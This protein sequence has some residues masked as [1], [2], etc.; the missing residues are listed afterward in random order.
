MAIACE[1][2]AK[3]VKGKQALAIES[4]AKALRQLPIIIAQNAGFDAN[5]LIHDLQIELS[6]R[7]DA[8]INVDTGLVDSMETLSITVLLQLFSN[9]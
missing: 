5:E 4:Y 9:V 8:G 2:H 3:T 6:E 7:P 1:Q